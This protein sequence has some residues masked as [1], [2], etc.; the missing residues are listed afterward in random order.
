MTTD[1]R[2]IDLTVLPAVI[3]TYLAAHRRHEVETAI[4]AFTPDAT[5]TDEGR[6]MSGADAIRTWLARAAGE[7]TYTIEP[8]GAAAVGEGRYDVVHHLE[9]D[10]PGGQVDLH[11]RFTLRDDHIRELVIEP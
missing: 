2:A 9:G 5:V 3:T 1:Q 10:F 7:Y 4:A 8:I 6:T 11:F